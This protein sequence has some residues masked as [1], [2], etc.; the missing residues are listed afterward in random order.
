MNNMSFY[1]MQM[2]YVLTFLYIMMLFEQTRRNA[3]SKN[4]CFL[5]MQWAKHELLTAKTKWYVEIQV[6]AVRLHE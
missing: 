1:D 4:I 5:D 6:T 3:I 2:C